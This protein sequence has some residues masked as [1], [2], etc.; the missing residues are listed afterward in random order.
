MANLYMVGEISGKGFITHED[1][2]NDN[3]NP[4]TI[5]NLIQVAD[6]EKARAWIER[7]GMTLITL[8]EAQ[9]THAANVSEAQASFDL[10]IKTMRP[11][12]ITLK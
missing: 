3:I 11:T 12:E 8:D 9:S 1:R 2:E 6:S 7:N 10:E 4:V 5:G